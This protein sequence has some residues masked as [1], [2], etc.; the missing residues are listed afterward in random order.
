[1]VQQSVNF[2]CYKIIKLKKAA[3]L[4]YERENQNEKTTLA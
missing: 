2:K 3:A 4:A 1:M